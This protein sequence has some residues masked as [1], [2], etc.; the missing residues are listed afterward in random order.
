MTKRSREEILAD[1]PRRTRG[2]FNTFAK[3]G[4]KI[5]VS[6]DPSD[7]HH[8]VELQKTLAKDKGIGVFPEDYLKKQLSQPFSSLYLVKYNPAFADEH[9][10]PKAEKVIAAVLIFD[11]AT[12]RHYIQAAQ[13]KAYTK[14]AAPSIVVCQMLVDAHEQGIKKFDFWGIAPE[15]APKN[16]PWKGFTKFKQSFGGEPIEYAGTYD[17]ILKPSKYRLY[18]IFR[19]LNRFIRKH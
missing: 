1:V 6:R 4:L 13:D 11:T 14:L 9:P 18:Q 12:T 10:D 8:L 17:I 7:I 16:H 5:E 2:Y 15:N 3:K 19:T